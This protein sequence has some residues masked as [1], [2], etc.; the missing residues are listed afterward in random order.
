MKKLVLALSA[1]AAFAAPALAADMAAKAPLRPAPVAYAPSW[2]GCY[3]GGGGGYGMW[4]QENVGYLEPFAVRP[5]AL[6]PATALTEAEVI[7]V[8]APQGT[9]ATRTRITDTVTSGGR[10]WFGTVQG[11]CDYQFGLGP[12]QLV[13]G[14][15]GDYDFADIHGR[16]AFA[17]LPLVAD[18]K[19]SS[20]WAVGGRIG[21]VALPNLMVFFSGGY[22]EARFDRQNYTNLF[23]PPFGIDQGAF[24]DERTYKGWFLGAGDE[25][26]LNFLPGLF[27][28]TEY[29][30]SEF[31]RVQSNVLFRTATGLPT[32]FS[33][34]SKKWVQTVRSELVYRFN[35]SGVG[36]PTR[37]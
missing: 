31:S 7:R 26:A 18:E 36:G 14:A 5:I 35:W 30:V 34:D 9:L 24:T 12:Y 1:A 22:T 20:Q 19:L 11:G 13:I 10:G 8:A 4:N 3:V 21:W 27:W 32:I 33:E 29:R 23:G 2:T 16:H 17:G 25:Y 15:F 37:Y 28:K 6:A